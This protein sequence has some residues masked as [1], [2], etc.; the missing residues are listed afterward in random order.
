[1]RTRRKQRS[2]AKP[3]LARFAESRG[4]GPSTII[5]QRDAH[6]IRDRAGNA[7]HARS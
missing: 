5:R 4:A 1:M 6:S 2:R 7:I 3:S